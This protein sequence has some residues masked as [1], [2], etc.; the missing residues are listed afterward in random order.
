MKY[1]W[2]GLRE[3]ARRL[4]RHHHAVQKA[5]S[6][7]RVPAASV[8]RDERGRVVAVDFPSASIA[9]RLSTDPSQALRRAAA[10]V[11]VPDEAPC[12]APPPTQASAPAIA[13]LELALVVLPAALEALGVGGALITLGLAAVREA[14]EGELRARGVDDAEISEL[15]GRLLEMI[16]DE[17]AQPGTWTK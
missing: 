2:L 9:W 15:V 7:G 17:R 4:G 5:I 8:R 11:N 1:E 10:P 14:M 12:Q 6:D 3:F 16:D 13:A